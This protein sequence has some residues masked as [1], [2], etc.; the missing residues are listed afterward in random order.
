MEKES[1]YFGNGTMIKSCSDYK[2]LYTLD[3]DKWQ[4]L[5]YR[6]ENKDTTYIPVLP[7]RPNR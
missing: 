7:N 3:I 2:D 4:K 6:P 1:V 5:V